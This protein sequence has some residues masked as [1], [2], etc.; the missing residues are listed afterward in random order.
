MPDPTDPK[1]EPPSGGS[2]ADPTPS[3]PRSRART[4]LSLLG[5]FLNALSDKITKAGAV[6]AA[7]LALGAV[8]TGVWKITEWLGHEI[9][10][11]SSHAKRPL[12]ATRTSTV[13]TTTTSSKVS[14]V[15][16]KNA[17]K[18]AHP[19]HKRP[20]RSPGDNLHTTTTSMTQTHTEYV[21]PP[22]TTTNA[23]PA[24]KPRPSTPKITTGPTKT[25]TINGSN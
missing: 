14:P 15:A 18:R 3:A 25:T 11:G 9:V 16:V 12:S 6:A 20:Q 24:E 2:S 1:T 23:V 7:L 5:A 13:A 17:L 10:T 8:G 21:P 19:V 22:V 4:W